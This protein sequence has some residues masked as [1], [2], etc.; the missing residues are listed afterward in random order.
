VV[1]DTHALAVSI[2]RGCK[3]ATLRKTYSVN[4]DRP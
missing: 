1:D 3:R 2:G 4:A